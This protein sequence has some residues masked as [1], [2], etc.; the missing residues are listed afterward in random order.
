MSRFNL[1]FAVV[2]LGNTTL[3]LH[4]LEVNRFRDS[5]LDIAENSLRGGV[6]LD[7]SEGVAN[8]KDLLSDVMSTVYSPEMVRTTPALAARRQPNSRAAPLSR[9]AHTPGPGASDPSEAL[10]SLCRSLPAPP[11]PRSQSARPRAPAGPVALEL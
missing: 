6:A 4:Q 11:A 9:T 1:E 7:K 2:R 8:G 5:V 10:A 3:V